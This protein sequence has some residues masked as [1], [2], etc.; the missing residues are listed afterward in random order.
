MGVVV[1]DRAVDFAEEFL[2]LK[3]FELALQAVHDI[4]GFFAQSGRCGGLV[5]GAAHHRDGGK[6]VRHSGEFADDFGKFGQDDGFARL[7]QHQGVGQVVDVFAGAGEV[8]ELAH[9]G[10]FRHFGK[11]FFSQYSMALT[12]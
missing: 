6:V 12:S 9:G 11:T 7:L 10:D 1:A 2:R 5:V 4:G 3:D 8:D